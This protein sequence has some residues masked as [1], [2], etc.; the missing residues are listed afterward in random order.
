MQ[1][2][3]LEDEAAQAE[4]LQLWLGNAGHHVQH[5]AAGAPFI[6]AINSDTFDLLILDWNLPDT[7]GIKVLRQLRERIDWPVPVLFLTSR[8]E[9]K[10][11]VLALEQGADDYIKKPAKRL[12]LLA[13]VEALLRRSAQH[14]DAQTV[15]ELAPYLIELS[16]A[17]HIQFN[18]TRV[19]LTQKELDLAI[20]LFINRGRLLSRNYILQSVWGI[21]AD[22]NTRTVDTHIRRLREKLG[23]ASVA[24]ETVRGA[25]Y[26]FVPDT[27]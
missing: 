20:L 14:A 3:L 12:E 17:R 16:N 8:D 22:L 5:Y 6:D 18:G 23:D 7:S 10:D 2:G 25:G 27:V 21:S 26:R 9:E 4:V 19:E 1:I 11:I 24:V 15:L 13:R